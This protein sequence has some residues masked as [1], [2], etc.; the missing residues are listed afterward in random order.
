MAAALEIPPGHETLLTA[1]LPDLDRARA[2]T[3]RLEDGIDHETGA[4][5]HREREKNNRTAGHQQRPLRRKELHDQRA[6]DTAEKHGHG[7]IALVAQPRQRL[8]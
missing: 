2:T 7:H 6:K 4:D 5:G 8:Q 1:E 3:V